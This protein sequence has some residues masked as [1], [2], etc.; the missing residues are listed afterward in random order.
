MDT[1][2]HF[3]RVPIEDRLTERQGICFRASRHL[4]Q[5]DMHPFERSLPGC[6]HSQ[7]ETQLA[8]GSLMGCGLK[9]VSGCAQENLSNGF[10]RPDGRAQDQF[11]LAQAGQQGCAYARRKPF[12]DSYQVS[13]CQAGLQLRQLTIS[14]FPIGQCSESRVSNSPPGE[15]RHIRRVIN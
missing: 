14:G 9:T 1:M 2:H 11:A 15:L 6:V 13:R 12:G 10:S 8:V 7:A 4:P 3:G 5:L